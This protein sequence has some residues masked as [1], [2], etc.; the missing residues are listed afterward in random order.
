MDQLP[1]GEWWPTGQHDKVAVIT[2]QRGWSYEVVVDMGL[3]VSLTINPAAKQRLTQGALRGTQLNYL[4]D[5]AVSFWQEV[6]AALADAPATD[7]HPQGALNVLPVDVALLL[8]SGEVGQLGHVVGKPSI[9]SFAA[10]WNAT[11]ARATVEGKVVTR[12]EALRS[13]YRRPDGTKVSAATI[14]SWTREARDLGL[15][16]A[17]TTGRGNKTPDGAVPSGN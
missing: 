6:D 9:G 12:R 10:T 15:I 11:P 3:V 16:E 2:D 17:A 5:A 14:D 8:A 7:R 4:R 1:S 13:R